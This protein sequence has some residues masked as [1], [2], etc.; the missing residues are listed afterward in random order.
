[1]QETSF[2]SLLH[3]VVVPVVLNG[4]ERRFILDSGIGLTLVRAGVDGCLPTGSSFTGKRMSGQEVAVPLATAPSLAFAGVEER[5]AGVGL[6]D[7]D[8]FPHELAEIDGFLSLAFFRRRPF[9]VDYER[10]TIRDGTRTAGTR[11]PVRV[12][13]DGPAVTAFMPLAI[14]GGRTVAVEL[15]MGSDTLILD[16]RLAPETGVQL[17]AAGL[18]REEGVDET[19]NRYVRT[20]TRLDGRIHPAEAPDLAQPEPDV[21]FQRIIYDGLLGH[22]FL[23]RF[24]VTWDLPAS[25]VRL[26]PRLLG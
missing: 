13:V 1:V 24:T 3:L 9:T 15:D 2:E 17:D 4:T 5:E 25:E 21:M 18:R 23:S 14:P 8:G 6:L 20:F 19:G 7:M 22:G 10:R 11:V 16:E 12:Q 26:E